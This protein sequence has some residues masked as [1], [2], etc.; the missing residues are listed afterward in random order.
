MSPHNDELALLDGRS[1]RFLFYPDVGTERRAAIVLKHAPRQLAFDT[2]GSILFVSYRDVG[3]LDV[4]SVLS[5]EV[6]HTIAC[7][8]AVMAFALDAAGHFLATLDTQGALVVYRTFLG[9][10]NIGVSVIEEHRSEVP[11]VAGAGPGAGSA[12]A[13]M[14]MSWGAGTLPRLYAPAG[15]GV[16]VVEKDADGVW[17]TRV[18]AVP[19]SNEAAAAA[20]AVVRVVASPPSESQTSAHM[21]ACAYTDGCVTVLDGG[22][23]ALVR[24]MQCGTE[25][26][27]GMLWTAA[28]AVGE[29]AETA[30]APWRLL[31][32]GPCG[33][34]GV[35]VLSSTAVAAAV[36]GGE[37]TSAV[38]TDATAATEVADKEKEEDDDDDDIDWG[39]AS[40]P[41]HLS[42]IGASKSKKR[43]GVVAFRDD[44]DETDAD[45]AMVVAED[46]DMSDYHIPAVDVQ[47]AFAPTRSSYDD[48]GMRFLCWNLTG[49][50]RVTADHARSNSVEV[51]FTNRYSCSHPPSQD[52]PTMFYSQPSLPVFHS[53][54]AAA[55]CR[56]SMCWRMAREA[57]C[58]PSR[59][60]TKSASSWWRM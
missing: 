43:G 9:N 8:S 49:I 33:V 6:L 55:F 38:A 27:L 46:V 24:Q 57:L 7:A 54:S 31:V 42:G 11:A 58:P 19:P 25:A 5:G 35:D 36:L 13:G 34:G 56:T 26:P 45:R 3:N 2:K 1:V 59:S 40:G 37:G 52:S 16:A 17:S 50:V 21:V 10:R 4:Y 53:I 44:A 60:N 15:A 32:A 22:S 12:G 51:K 30:T 39:E 48:D 18:L 29:E 14:S 23:G 41:T 28:A 20:A 47:Q